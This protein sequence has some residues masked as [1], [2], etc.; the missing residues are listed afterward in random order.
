MVIIVILVYCIYAYIHLVPMYKNE[1]GR[2]FWVNLTITI[3][4]FI[5]AILLSLDVELPSPANF[6]KN[7]ITAILGK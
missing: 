7:S 2:D 3:L 6:I 1:A 5:V 4:S